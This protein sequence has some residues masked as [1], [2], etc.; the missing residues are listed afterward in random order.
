MFIESKLVQFLLRSGIHRDAKENVVLS[1]FRHTKAN[2]SNRLNRCS[3]QCLLLIASLD[4]NKPHCSGI[5][6]I[7][8]L[9]MPSNDMM[10]KF[11]SFFFF[12]FGRS[13]KAKALSANALNLHETRHVQF[14]YNLYCCVKLALQR[15][16]IPRQTSTRENGAGSL[17]RAMYRQIPIHSLP[18]CLSDRQNIFFD[19]ANSYV[20]E[21]CCRNSTKYSGVRG[22]SFQKLL[23]EVLS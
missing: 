11:L 17:A 1:L 20:K 19:C 7:N 4:F 5:R 3:Q 22:W 2:R 18:Y 15:A 21:K 9:F 6:K 14:Y 8:S 13:D 12:F 16:K 23:Y 10:K